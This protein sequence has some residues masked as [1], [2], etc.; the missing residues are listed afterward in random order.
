MYTYKIVTHGMSAKFTTDETSLESIIN[1]LKC[2]NDKLEVYKL[3]QNGKGF[4]LVRTIT[5]DNDN[6]I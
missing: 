2:S 5:I 3:G 1:L 4:Q 6:R